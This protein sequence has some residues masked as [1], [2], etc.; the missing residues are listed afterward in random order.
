MVR[1]RWRYDGEM[2]AAARG[3]CGAPSPR[4]YRREVPIAPASRSSASAISR[5][6]APARRRWRCALRRSWRGSA[7]QPPFSRAASA[8]GYLVRIGSTLA[9][10]A[11][12]MSATSRC[13][14]R[15]R[16]RRWLHGIVAAGARAIEAGASAHRSPSSWTTACR[17]RS[18]PRICSRRRRWRA[19]L[20]QRPRHAGRAAARAARLPA[21]VDGCRR[22]QHAAGALRE[23][24]ADWLRQSFPGPV[25][26]ATVTRARPHLAR[27][28][29]RRR[30]RRHRRAAAVLRLAR[31]ARRRRGAHRDICRSPRFQPAEAEHLLG[32]A[33]GHAALLVTTEKDW[34]RWYERERKAG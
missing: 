28:F 20:R 10:T 5:R 18:S 3:R 9:P 11:Q 6:E 23:A 34:A 21:R 29:R 13:C 17:T 22:R 33:E 15:A 7:R 2:P 14:W 1:V 19:R 32:L 8:A 27:G 12:P 31:P 30:L 16:G 26:A 24:A 25:L 4:R